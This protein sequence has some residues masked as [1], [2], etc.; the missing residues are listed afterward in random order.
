LEG[1]NME[2]EF[3]E[4]IQKLSF[5]S[6]A[7]Y[8][9]D[10]KKLMPLAEGVL[11]FSREEILKICDELFLFTVYGLA[12]TEKSKEIT[13]FINEYW[14]GKFQYKKGTSSTVRFIHF[15]H[16]YMRKFKDSL[17]KSPFEVGNIFL[18]LETK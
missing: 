12:K 14:S 1:K 15:S 18:G 17:E 8:N 4:K 5:L 6:M 16:Y 3:I 7:F 2:K 13:E 9:I 11:E 10:E